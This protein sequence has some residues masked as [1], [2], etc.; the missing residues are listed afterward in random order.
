MKDTSVQK[1]LHAFVSRR[2]FKPF[3]VELV[4]GDRIVVEHPEAFLMR[5]SAAVYLNPVGEYALFDS[6]TVSQLTDIR[7]N[8][9][10]S[11]RRRSSN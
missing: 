6:S 8:G 1:S 2:P 9:N 7:S 11:S 4:S 5:G 10:K 3:I